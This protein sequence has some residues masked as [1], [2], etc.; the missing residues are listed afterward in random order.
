[1][2]IVADLAQ[3]KARR[4]F[5]CNITEEV[6]GESPA[7]TLRTVCKRMAIDPP[8]IIHP[9]CP[10][11]NCREILDTNTAMSGTSA[12]LQPL[13]H[14]PACGQDWTPVGGCISATFPR[15]PL[16]SG[17]ERLMA[18]PGV[19][20][21]T[22]NWRKQRQ[23]EARFMERSYAGLK[24]Y[25]DQADG[26]YLHSLLGPEG[27]RMDEGP[28]GDTKEIFLNL[29]LDWLNV[30]SSAFG[31]GYAVGPIILQMANLPQALRGLQAM[32]T[33]VGL[34]PGTSSGLKPK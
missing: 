26:T 25:R 21:L 1:M 30:R 14:C 6:I 8:I 34:T 19:E 24:I 32:V 18:Y 29:S 31:P 9:V 11:S 13:S 10:N 33:C 17:I 20:R 4:G 2:L 5:T 28:F 3:I 12:V 27:N 15:I 7:Q 23:I 16:I 22:F